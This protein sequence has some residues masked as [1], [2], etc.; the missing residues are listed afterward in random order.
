M[1]E[2]RNVRGRSVPRV[3]CNEWKVEVWSE[4]WTAKPP[5]QPFKVALVREQARARVLELK[6]TILFAPEL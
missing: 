3:I 4:G 1:I 5:P 6:E 2:I